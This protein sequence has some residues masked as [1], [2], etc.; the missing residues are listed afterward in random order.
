MVKVS[1]IIKALNEEDN[2]VKAVESSLEAVAPF[3]GEVIV[4]DSGSTDRTIELAMPFPVKIVQLAHPDER[5]CGIGPELG[6]EASEG[7][8]VYILDG[9][10]QIDAAFIRTAITFL[11]THPRV[12]GVGGYV[13]EMRIS[14][15][16]F[17]NRV[18]RQHRDQPQSAREVGSLGGGGLY[19][20]TAIQEVGYLSD[21]NLHSFEEYD[22]GARLRAKGWRLV[23]LQDH[24]ADHYSYSMGT[25]RLLWFRIRAGYLWGTG[26]IFRA[27]IDSGYLRSVLFELRAV[28]IAIGLWAYWFF[29]ALVAAVIPAGFAPF[30]LVL[31]VLLLPAIMTA[32]TRSLA[33]GF[34]SVLLWHV[35]AIGFLVGLFRKR[36][37][38]LT[39]I[40]SNRLRT[41]DPPDVSHWAATRTAHFTNSPDP[42]PP[43]S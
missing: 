1:I 23:R 20:R 34:Y 32:R 18:A 37:S 31:A 40:E 8:Y 29:A 43:A 21:R 5:C 16:E 7:Q 42:A 15:L 17:K 2:I 4:A 27:S 14:N 22:L 35:N 26:E 13:R 11:D 12:A 9:D 6:Y 19:R 38:P 39:R 3:G 30:F 10:M 33:R 25:Y 28:H 41:V 36:T 24:A